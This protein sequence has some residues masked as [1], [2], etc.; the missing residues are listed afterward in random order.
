M[1]THIKSN[2]QLKIAALLLGAVSFQSSADVILHAFNWRYDDVASKA[3]EIA[4]LGYKKST[5]LSRL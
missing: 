1:T 3:Q 2:K 5:R 4:E